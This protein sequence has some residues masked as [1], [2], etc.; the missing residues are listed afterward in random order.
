MK[1]ALLIIGTLILSIATN[2]QFIGKKLDITYNY[3][4]SYMEAEFEPNTSY[5]MI[6]WG[7]Q[8][9]LLKNQDRKNMKFRSYAAF[10]EYL[11]QF[12]WVYIERFPV[13]NSSSVK[14]VFKRTKS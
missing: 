4:H 6:Y 10:F 12:G 7:K 14:L 1:K 13:V 5:I 9:G 11:E 3:A 2:A 8:N